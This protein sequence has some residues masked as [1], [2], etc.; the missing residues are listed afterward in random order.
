[1]SQLC[2]TKYRARLFGAIPVT[3]SVAYF[4]G[5]HVNR[6]ALG[7]AIAALGLGVSTASAQQKSL[8]DQIV[9]AWILVS[10]SNIA[11][12]GS[13]RDLWGPN[14]TGTLIFDA[15]GRFAQIITRSDIPKFKANNRLQGTPEENAASVRGTTASFGAWSANEA[16]KT[17]TVRNEGGMYPNQNGD[18]SKRPVS[19][20]AEELKITT[21]TTA[22]GMRAE[23][24]W[25]RAK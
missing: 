9:G 23:N 24:T 3:V 11:A 20:S 19:V 22:A 16:D 10:T 21:P 25:R 15:S 4:R 13:K 14:P 2:P 17:L 12:D 1:V 7:I 6:I 5:Y 18:E 8:K